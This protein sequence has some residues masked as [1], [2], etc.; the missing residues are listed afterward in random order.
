MKRKKL[1]EVREK[2]TKVVRR[3]KRSTLAQ[4]Q[5]ISSD[6]VT[7]DK[8]MQVQ[9]M[10][11]RVRENEAIEQ[12]SARVKESPFYNFLK[13]NRDF[14]LGLDPSLTELEVVAFLQ[15]KWESL[16]AIEQEAYSQ[17]E[18]RSQIDQRIS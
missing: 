5:A 11:C 17:I 2:V 7:D 3:V 1:D 12:T 8:E 4:L 15:A 9:E 18:Q 10:L 6:L 16:S 14:V 13:E